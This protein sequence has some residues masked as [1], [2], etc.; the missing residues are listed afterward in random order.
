MIEFAQYGDGSNAS[1]GIVKTLADSLFSMDQV[2]NLLRGW[3]S[4]R[5]VDVYRRQLISM[6]SSTGKLTVT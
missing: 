6:P 3:S 4:G 5:R 2:L 1:S